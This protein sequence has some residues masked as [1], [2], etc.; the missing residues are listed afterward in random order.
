M[1]RQRTL[2]W[3]MFGLCLLALPLA[4]DA[5]GMPCYV[6][7]HFR[8]R[9]DDGD[10]ATATWKAEAD[11]PAT[12]VP[13][14]QNIRLRFCIS[15]Q[16]DDY[17][18]YW[19]NFE[20][21]TSTNGPWMAVA[22]SSGGGFPFEFSDSTWFANDTLAGNLLPGTGVFLNKGAMV[23]IDD[24]YGGNVDLHAGLTNGMYINAE[25]CLRPTAK[26]KGGAT[27]YFR[28]NPE[29]FATSYQYAVLTMESYD[30]PETPAILNAGNA[31]TVRV[32][33]VGYGLADYPEQT[34]RILASGSEPMTYGATGLPAGY[35]LF[36][37][38]IADDGTPSTPGT[39]TVTVTTR[40]A[41]GSDTKTVTL[42]V[43]SNQVPGCRIPV[44]GQVG[45]P[46]VF[47]LP[48]GGS[49]PLTV[50][51]DVVGGGGLPAGLSFDGIRTISGTPQA[52]GLTRLIATPMNAA[53]ATFSP[54]PS[55]R[56]I[57]RIEDGASGFAIDGISMTPEPE[58]SFDSETG[59]LYTVQSKDDL[60]ATNAW[61]TLLGNIAG[62]GGTLKVVDGE[63]ASKRVY[64]I[65]V[66]NP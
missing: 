41:Y 32:E 20:Y 24:S 5:N 58:L 23:D 43:D 40:N 35:A 26:A 51:L 19:P 62:T 18:N 13:H 29:D 38:T 54:L 31:A 37:D 50:L 15:N 21:A 1:T 25:L 11:T 44:S 52:A 2:G 59:R 65:K 34:F 36:G 60:V 53:N 3:W 4:A 42:V 7:E 57:L 61:R 22:P 30:P 39:N 17:G 45:T 28:L 48:V 55:V 6:Q 27:Y 64:K 9:N 8:W 49:G 46:L 56:I 12:N 10:A 63:G 14:N 16:G 47:T 33:K 66:T